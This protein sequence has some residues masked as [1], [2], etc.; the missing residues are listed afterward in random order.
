MSL[1]EI[2]KANALSVG[3]IGGYGISMGCSQRE[4]LG[5][6]VL[7][8]LLDPGHLAFHSLFLPQ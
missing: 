4:S 3:A 8:G 1:L 6:Q 2:S 5:S 7:W